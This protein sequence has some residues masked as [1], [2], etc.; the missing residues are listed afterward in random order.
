MIDAKILN[1]ALSFCDER[2]SKYT[3]CIHF[4]NDREDTRDVIPIL[5]NILFG[6]SMVTTFSKEK[7]EKGIA[8]I[9]R[10]FHF[11]TEHGFVGCM[12]D[13]PHVYSDRPNVWI[14]LALSHF[15]ENFSKV[16]PS[17]NRTKIEVVKNK[18]ISILQTRKLGVIDQ[19]IFDT[20]LFKTERSE[21]EPKTLSEYE[22]LVLCKLMMKEQVTLPWHKALGAYIGP[23]EGVSYKAFDRTPS[24]FTQ[25]ATNSGVHVSALF[26]AL[27][28]KKGVD[29]LIS[30]PT[31][32][33]DDL[34]VNHGGDD[35]SIHF[36]NH[37]L[38]GKGSFD[39]VVEGDHI[40]I[41]LDDFEEEIPFYLSDHGSS[42]L[43]IDDIR[44]TAFYPKDTITLTTD[45]KSLTMKFTCKDH[46]FMG[47]IMKGNRPNQ[48]LDCDRNFSLYDHKLLLRKTL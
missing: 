4:K 22:T 2:K 34:F 6:I 26:A 10:M 3:G 9:E 12:H 24:L 48:L 20:A 5:E 27:L 46:N 13:F 28:P 39:I 32:D 16:I 1:N 44:A 7:A 19:Y 25:L 35:L 40:D 43:Y 31:F 15:L 45:N 21:F 36:D 47:H 38:T 41:I 8:H 23:L 14:C 18:L 11:F 33:R 30:Y 37:T 29:D 17:S 42:S